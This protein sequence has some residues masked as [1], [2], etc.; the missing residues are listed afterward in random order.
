[1]ISTK[2]LVLVVYPAV[3][4]ALIAECSKK[5]INPTEIYVDTRECLKKGEYE[6]LEIFA[7]PITQIWL[8]PH[9]R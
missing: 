4:Y 5:T 1:M 8:T 7:T 2:E 3:G 6:I 9:Y